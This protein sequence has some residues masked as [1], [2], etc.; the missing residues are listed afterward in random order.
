MLEPVG[1]GLIFAAIV[2]AW[3]AYLVP[4]YLRRQQHDVDVDPQEGFSS[5]ARMVTAGV[6]PL[7]DQ[8]G[9]EI[10]GVEIS[11]PMTRRAAVRRLSMLERRAAAR[12]RRV[13]ITLLVVLTAGLVTA[14]LGYLPWWALAIPGGLMVLFLGVSRV[15][16]R[17]ML[18]RHDELAAEILDGAEQEDTVRIA[19]GPRVTVTTPGAE[20]AETRPVSGLWE[21]IPVTTPTYVSKPLAPRTVRTIDLSA[22]DV[23]SSGR[24]EAPVLAETAPVLP[25]QN[26][27]EERAEDETRRRASGE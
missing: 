1:T 26:R 15:T 12:R 17:W 13:L 20:R 8:D 14:S 16:V 9:S 23:T 21:P 6:V 10:S 25:P 3:L 4:L 11:T 22:P 19:V 2:A 27:A 7:V 5:T 24:G 18:R